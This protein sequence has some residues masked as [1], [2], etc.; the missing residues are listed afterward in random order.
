MGMV[1]AVPVVVTLLVAGIA[2]RGA[3]TLILPDLADSEIHI[4]R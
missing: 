2:A 1:H 4:V 3:K